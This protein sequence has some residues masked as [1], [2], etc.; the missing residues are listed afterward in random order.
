MPKQATTTAAPRL[1]V[2]A[3]DWQP[4]ARTSDFDQY[5]KDWVNGQTYRVTVP[6]TDIEEI[7]GVIRG[8]RSAVQSTKPG[9][10]CRRVGLELD[11]KTDRAY[12]YLNVRPKT[13]RTRNA[14]A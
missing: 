4:P 10:S 5:V 9:L 3:T 2:E 7:E 14:S 11:T 8:L 1:H 6:S 13:T 12:I